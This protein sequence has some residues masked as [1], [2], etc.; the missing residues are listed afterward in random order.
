MEEKNEGIFFCQKWVFFRLKKGEGLVFQ[1]G[2]DFIPF[3]RLSLG[4][5]NSKP[6]IA[7]VNAC[8]YIIRR[9]LQQKL[10]YIKTFD[11]GVLKTLHL[12]RI[13]LYQIYVNRISKP[14]D[15]LPDGS[16]PSLTLEKGELFSLKG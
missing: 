4:K 13:F 2:E 1:S 8:I 6:W 3:N 15:L 11:L 10:I 12:I 16:I 14:M 5:I 7:R 9:I